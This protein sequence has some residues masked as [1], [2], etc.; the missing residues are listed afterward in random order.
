M[1]KTPFAFSA[2]IGTLCLT[3]TALWLFFSYSPIELHAISEIIPDRAIIDENGTTQLEGMVYFVRQSFLSGA[4]NP[5]IWPMYL[6][7]GLALMAIVLILIG[8]KKWAQIPRNY[9]VGGFIVWAGLVVGTNL[10][11]SIREIGLIIIEQFNGLGILSLIASAILLSAAIPR[12]LFQVGDSNQYQQSRRNWL[13]LFGFSLSNLILTYG[14]E[15]LGWDI[16]F[17]IPGLIFIQ[18]AWVAYSFQADSMNSWL[19]WGINLLSLSTLLYF[20]ISGNDPGINA[21]VHGSLICQ[22][23]MLFLFPLFII[24]NFKTPIQQHLPVYKIIHKAPHVDL[25]LIYLGV[26]ILGSAWVYAKNASVI[27]QFQA[28]FYNERGDMES[29]A[30]NR[31]SAEFAYQQA[32]LHSKLNAKSNLSLAALAL[33][34]NDYETAAYYLATS[35]QK[36]ASESAYLALANIYLNND[37]AF[38][39]LFMLQKAQQQFPESL[40]ILTSLAKQF[41]SL[42]SIDSANYY[43]Q[44]AYKLHP[45]NSISQGN[46]LYSA[47]MPIEN[48]EDTDPAVAANNLAIAL[49]SKKSVQIPAPETTQNPG[50]DLRQWAY[51]YNYQLYAKNQ[52]PEYPISQW[53]K[54]PLTAAAF[55]EYNLI[56]AWQ[57]YHH[58]K[59]LTALQKLDLLIK[60]DTTATGTGLKSMLD[61][62]KTSLLKPQAT[63]PLTTLQMA[64]N[65]LRQYP[66]QVDV[67]QQALPLLN[68]NKQ[69]KAGYDAA[70]AALQ[71]NEGVPVYY[72]IFAM[73]A[74]QIGEITYGNEAVQELKK[75]N[76]TI[77]LANQAILA[78]ALQE[79]IRRQNF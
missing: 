15:F 46:M 43:Y 14:K 63:Q 20:Q 54:N 4:S 17:A 32:M 5:L 12:L 21:F 33:Q 56:E 76:P 10:H 19:R 25:R 11:H 49:K 70:L 44:K 16:T 34:A 64:Q 1:P 48:N 60:R 71:W 51:V 79:A 78:K 52:S 3:S 8:L 40:E 50:L 65:A 41:E 75:R 57:A 66:F 73:Q 47:K 55:P 35:L 69:E 74:Y 42:K 67:L 58:G 29:Q 26:F 45:N 39:A 23:V 22:S 37:H 28:A 62:W 36:H 59:P 9:F 53:V 7:S 13:I 2:F 24:S 30:E 18:I 31:K 77:Y 72:L 38:E 61:F 6:Y 27:H 68:K